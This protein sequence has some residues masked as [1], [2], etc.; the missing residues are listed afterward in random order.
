MCCRYFQSSTAAA[1]AVYVPAPAPAGS[2]ENL[3][4]TTVVT[5]STRAD[6]KLAHK[7]RQGSNVAVIDTQINTHQKRMRTIAATAAVAE[8]KWAKKAT[9]K[10]KQLPS[11]DT[12]DG[13]CRAMGWSSSTIDSECGRCRRCGAGSVKTASI[14]AG[15]RMNGDGYGNVVSACGKC[16]LLLWQS[17]DDA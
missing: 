3:K 9:K 16:G 4:A 1:A 11:M 14:S 15:C 10:C 13:D 5:T 7:R 17:Y 8:K 2:A 12:K 6:R